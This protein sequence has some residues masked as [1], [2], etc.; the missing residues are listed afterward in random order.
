MACGNS[1]HR[2]VYPRDSSS[3][4]ICQPGSAGT[5]PTCSAARPYR[6]LIRS[7]TCISSL[8]LPLTGRGQEIRR[9]LIRLHDAAQHHRALRVGVA[10]AIDRVETGQSGLHQDAGIVG[11]V[12]QLDAQAAVVAALLGFVLAGLHANQQR[13]AQR[14]CSRSFSAARAA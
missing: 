2:V 7:T 1:P 13:G 10:L 11:W 4:R 8:G 5:R 12:R 14:P 9:E 6:A 3:R